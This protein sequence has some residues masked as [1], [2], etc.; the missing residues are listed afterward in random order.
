MLRMFVDGVR[1]SEAAVS[2][3]LRQGEA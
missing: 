2:G 1:L 3:P